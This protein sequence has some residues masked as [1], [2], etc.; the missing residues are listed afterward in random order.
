V[1]AGTVREFQWSNPHTWI[2]LDVPDASGKVTITIHPMRS[3]EPGD[4][5][6]SAVFADGRTLGTR[7]QA[8]ASVAAPK[9]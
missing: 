3:G 6:V 9:P 7:T 2:Q 8:P 1:L 4:S 5:F